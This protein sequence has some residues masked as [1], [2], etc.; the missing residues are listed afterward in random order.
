MQSGAFRRAGAQATR[1]EPMPVYQAPLD[2][3]RF[4]L[5]DVLGYE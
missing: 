5:N 3:M 2:D 4:V 1:T